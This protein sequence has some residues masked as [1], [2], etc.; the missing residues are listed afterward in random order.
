LSEFSTEHLKLGSRYLDDWQGRLRRYN[1]NFIS[2]LEAECAG[3]NNWDSALIC[4]F[5]QL[6]I[7]LT[8]LI[9]GIQY[10]GLNVAP[11]FATVFIGLS[12]SSTLT[13]LLI[14]MKLKTVKEKTSKHE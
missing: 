4:M 12:A 13:I 10:L 11:L 3:F 14:R 8:L 9:S 5:K 7:K 6:A 2:V 1:N